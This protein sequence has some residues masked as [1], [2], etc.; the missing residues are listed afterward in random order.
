MPYTFNVGDEI[1]A[2]RLNQS[3]PESHSRLLNA[4]Y[5]IVELYL[6]N[7]FSGKQTPF[8]G[9]FFDGF[10]DEQKTGSMVDAEISN[11]RVKIIDNVVTPLTLE[12]LVIAGG[13]GGGA[14]PP[15]QPGGGGGA[16]GYRT[17][18]GYLLS[19]TSVPITVG[20]G[21]AKNTNG[22]NSVFDAI[23][24]IGG[25]GGGGAGQAGQSASGNNG[26]NGGNGL[27][28]SITGTPITRGGGGGGDKD[29]GG[30]TNGTGGAGGGAAGESN[31]N[32][33]PN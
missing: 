20:N 11:R 13:G 8:Q 27:T 28:S 1:T 9:L 12:Y 23:T 3:D 31:T 18:T 7:Y 10:S 24:S 6:E 15:D 16:G 30:T 21:G 14:P 5:N 19:N 17:A 32:G 22:E 4:E 33:T 2:E 26:G 25:G 29:V